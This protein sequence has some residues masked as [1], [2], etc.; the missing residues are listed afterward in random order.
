M[1]KIIILEQTDVSNTFSFKYAL[2]ANVP[3]GREIVTTSSSAYTGATAAENV[4]IQAGRVL[5][6][7]DA[8]IFPTGATQGVI[9]GELQK[10]FVAFQ[11]QINNQNKTSRYGTSWDGTSWTITGTI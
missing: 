3:A 2:W 5:E 11:T 7:I 10:I 8:A 6:R 9:A 4:E 1:K